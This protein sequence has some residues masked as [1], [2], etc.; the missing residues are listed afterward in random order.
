M[1]NTANNTNCRECCA[2][3]RTDH[4]QPTRTITV[5]L[6]GNPNSGKTTIF[7]NLTGS[8]Q[9]VGNYPGVTVETREGTVKYENYKIKVVDLPGSYSLSA[10]SIEEI[11][12]QD[13]LLTKRP[14]VIVNV[15]DGSNLQRNLYLTTQLTELGS[16]LV[17][18]L[19][20]AD[21]I[22]K[23]GIAVDIET[24]GKN[25]NAYVVPTIGTRNKG[26]G[27]LLER[28]VET[29]MQ[30]RQT[31]P[32]HKIDYGEDIEQ[33]LEKLAGMLPKPTDCQAPPRWLALKL[34][35][36]DS[37]VTDVLPREIEKKQANN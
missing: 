3:C 34:L 4:T 31:P 24:L 26:T 2:N 37:S 7:N 20:M 18:A 27:R 11:F 17:V 36:N 1:K 28:I 23:K 32:P 9:H 19:N 15:V 25:I 21:E 29:A 30:N 33:E 35:E 6:A 10:Y 22:K 12:A 5:A 16:P 14:D 8:N 13:F